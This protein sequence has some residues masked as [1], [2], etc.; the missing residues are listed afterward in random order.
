MRH[1]ITL[2]RE[3]GEKVKIDVTLGIDHR[4]FYWEIDVSICAPRKRTFIYL[5]D[6]D[7]FEYRRLNVKERDS[8]RM[9]EFLKHVTKEEIQ[10]AC[11][12]LKE[13]IMIPDCNP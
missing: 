12:E 3:S 10:I 5:V 9:K 11:L 6:T 1:E 7:S 8:F 2:K 4:E 13:K